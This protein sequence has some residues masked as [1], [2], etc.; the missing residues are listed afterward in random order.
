[1]DNAPEDATQCSGEAMPRDA[2]PQPDSH[3]APERLGAR[4]RRWLLT[5][6]A[7]LDPLARAPSGNDFEAGAGEEQLDSG[8]EVHGAVEVPCAG[9]PSSV[10]KTLRTMRAY[11]GPGLLIAVGYMDPGNWCAPKRGP[12]YLH[13][14]PRVAARVLTRARAGVPASRAAAALGTIS[15]A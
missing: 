13:A 14:A 9:G 5:A 1:M 2:H 15:C 11:A 4:V 3:A 10:R 7:A 6:A 12:K 8:V